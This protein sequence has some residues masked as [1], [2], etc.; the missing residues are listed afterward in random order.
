M[1]KKEVGKVHVYDYVNYRSFLKDKFNELKRK[2]PRFSYHSFRRLSGMGSPSYLKMVT[3]GHR[4]LGDPGIAMVAR[5]F[6]LN[7][8]DTKYF[9][10][11]VKFNQAAT[12]EEKDRYFRE[13]SH[14]KKFL[15]AKPL[16]NAQ[17]QLFSHWYYVAIL[18]LL[19]LDAGKKKKN[20]EWIKKNLKPEVGLVEI[21]HAITALV[22]LGLLTTRSG[23][24]E[25]TEAMLKTD[26]DVED[27]AITNYHVQMCELAKHSVLHDTPHNREFAALTLITS[28]KGFKRAKQEIRMIR[29]NLH[30][31]MEQ[32]KEGKKT[33][34]AHINMQL[35]QMN[36]NLED[37]ND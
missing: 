4:N 15:E 21:R 32:D 18:E 10:T 3:E 12:T 20:T 23:V 22:S 35:F 37:E 36:R 14:H 13:L 17:Y 28:A 29:D 7:E 11:L 8:A 26:E 6:K 31:I 16:T 19:R 9:Y 34:V 27:I 33:I 2:N 5:G 1:G 30:S 24:L 25:C